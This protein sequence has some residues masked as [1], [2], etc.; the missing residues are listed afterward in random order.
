MAR[1]YDPVTHTEVFMPTEYTITYGAGI[2]DWWFEPMEEG[3]YVEYDSSGMPHKKV[4][5]PMV[6]PDPVEEKKDQLRREME[7][8]IG[9]MT[10]PEAMFLML[11]YG[12]QKMNAG[13]GGGQNDDPVPTIPLTPTGEDLIT[14][15]DRIAT[16]LEK[17]IIELRSL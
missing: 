6:P 4:L 11:Q 8:L 3:Y 15:G 5:P 14:W 7:A 12:M 10:T 17:K 1:F 9:D 13:S 16:E 2:I